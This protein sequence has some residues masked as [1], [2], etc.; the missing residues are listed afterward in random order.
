MFCTISNKSCPS[1]LPKSTFL[2]HLT[3][4]FRILLAS[5][6]LISPSSKS[7]VVFHYLLTLSKASHF[8]EDIVFLLFSYKSSS[9][10]PPLL[11]YLMHLRACKYSGGPL[12]PPLLL[13]VFSTSFFKNSTPSKHIIKLPS[14]TLPFYCHLLTSLSF[15]IIYW[16]CQHLVPD[17]FSNVPGD[18]HYCK[19]PS[20]WGLLVSLVLENNDL[21]STLVFSYC[22]AHHVSLIHSSPTQP[23][24]YFGWTIA[25]FCHHSNSYS[26][27]STLIVT[28]LSLTLI[29]FPHLL[30]LLLLCI[31][32]NNSLSIMKLPTCDQTSCNCFFI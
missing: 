21:F 4:S 9:C 5:K 23:P 18:F 6:V 14:S 8:L 7:S 24:D 10:P 19:D 15:Y 16:W 32:S 30:A 2:N 22:H 25:R 27:L 20:Q 1:F 17:F 31:Q 26:L 11:P 12:F 13:L 3:A 28:A 29:S